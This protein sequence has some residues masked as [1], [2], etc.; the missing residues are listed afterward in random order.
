MPVGEF[1]LA[2]ASAV[3]WSGASKGLALP[4][5]APATVGAAGG[6]GLVNLHV[7]TS[8]NLHAVADRRAADERGDIA[9]SLVGIQKKLERFELAAH[10][11]FVFIAVG[12]HA[13]LAPDV[14][15]LDG[16]LSVFVKAFVELIDEPG[17]LLDR[18]GGRKLVFRVFFVKE[19]LG[20]SLTG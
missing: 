19:A 11:V 6:F 9:A 18:G 20:L 3:S 2:R 16:D 15:T 13:V 14:G 4:S 12:R 1:V 5:R 17:E 10:L 8:V 7:S